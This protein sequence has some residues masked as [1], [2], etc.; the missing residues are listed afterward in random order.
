MSNLGSKNDNYI[1]RLE[2]IKFSRNTAYIERD[3]NSLES[4]L[5]PLANHHPEDG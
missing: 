4:S 2:E 1:R 3:M 5:T